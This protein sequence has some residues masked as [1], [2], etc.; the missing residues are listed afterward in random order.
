[1]FTR[2]VVPLD[3]SQFA[4]AAL[5]PARELARAFGS[6]ILL[7]RAVPP[8]GFPYVAGGDGF[9]SHLER[10][11]DADAYLHTVTEHLQEMGYD[12]DMALALAE[13]GAAI[14]EAA[15]IEHADLIV[16]SAHLRWKVPASAALSATLDVLVHSRVPLLAWRV[17]GLLEEEGGP[18]VG[19]RPPLLGRS[20][21]PLIVPLDGS[22]LAESALP[23]VE[24]LAQAFDLFA[25]LVRVV[26]R[27]EGVPAAEQSLQATAR[28]LAERGV[29]AVTVARA[30]EPL[31]VIERVW[32]EQDGGLIV[33]AS[34][35]RPGPHDTFFGSLT[36]RLIE[37]VEAPVLAVRPHAGL[38][39]QASAAAATAGTGSTPTI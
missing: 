6:R 33:M 9:Q 34:H 26:D 14:A 2:I 39:V 12:A 19:V 32:R 38:E 10:A 35:G 21:S 18:D 24:A 29:R 37:E 30:G 16:M 1:M 3:G 4:E 36:A 22:P 8:H 31:S 20:E 28:M 15:A 7:V 25:V 11:N 27:D 17:G 13:P 23:A 5:A